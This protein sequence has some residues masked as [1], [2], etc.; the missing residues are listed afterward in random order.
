MAE[1][2]SRLPP[3]GIA[4]KRL[5]YWYSRRDNC[6]SRSHFVFVLRHTLHSHCLS[7][8]IAIEPIIQLFH[9]QSCKRYL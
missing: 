5:V 8:G 1:K 3:N 2:K 7:T 9:L 4:C 6:T